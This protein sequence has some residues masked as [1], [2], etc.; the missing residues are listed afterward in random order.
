ML[1]T[2]A[3]SMNSGCQA[4]YELLGGLC[5]VGCQE[6]RMQ[7]VLP[8]WLQHLALQTLQETRQQADLSCQDVQHTLDIVKGREF[9]IDTVCKLEFLL[10]SSLDKAAP[11]PGHLE[12]CQ[13]MWQLKEAVIHSKPMNQRKLSK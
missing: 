2:A 7:S 12:R 11:A 13:A 6:L 9:G 3:S 8:W 5:D 10:N 1:V 4:R